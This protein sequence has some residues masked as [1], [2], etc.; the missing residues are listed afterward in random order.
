MAKCLRCGAGSEWL[1]GRKISSAA[2]PL[3][4]D[5]IRAAKFLERD[6][7]RLKVTY[8][9]QNNTWLPDFKAEK[10]RY[11]EMLRLARRLRRAAGKRTC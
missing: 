5:M 2:R 6:A 8:A 1:Q 10:I 4:D 3:T 9:F 11:D 7:T